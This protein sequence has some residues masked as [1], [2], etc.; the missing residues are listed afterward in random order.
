MF[1][2]GLRLST[3]NKENDDDDEFHA[4]QF[5]H[6]MK[7]GSRPHPDEIAG[8]DLDGDK[9][10]V[11]WDKDLIPPRTEKPTSYAGKCTHRSNYCF[12]NEQ[13]VHKFIILVSANWIHLYG[14]KFNSYRMLTID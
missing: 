11:C 2:N 8:S 6:W 9:Y 4:C 5:V 14:L 3:S 7:L 1:C 13:N 10:F 12:W